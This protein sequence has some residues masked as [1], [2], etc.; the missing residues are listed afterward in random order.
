MALGRE[1]A[2]H[3]TTRFAIRQRDRGTLPE[4]QTSAEGAPGAVRI[5][6]LAASS[7]CTASSAE[8]RSATNWWFMALR[9]SGRFSVSRMMPSS[10]RS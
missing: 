4:V 9:R 2:L 1:A 6:T 8:W 3:P 7:S 10:P 5:T